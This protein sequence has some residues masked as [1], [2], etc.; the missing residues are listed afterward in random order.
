[1][2]KLLYSITLL[3]CSLPSFASSITTQQIQGSAIQFNCIP[4]LDTIINAVPS[5]INS[6]TMDLTNACDSLSAAA[7]AYEDS[8]GASS[9]LQ[10]Q[11]DYYYN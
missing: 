6:F 8:A 11:G 10:T 5:A 9:D 2:K 7:Q 1:M 4:A 3:S